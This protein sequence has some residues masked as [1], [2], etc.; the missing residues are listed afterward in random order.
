MG[1]VRRWRS[2][3]GL[4][5]IPFLFSITITSVM[6]NIAWLTWVSPAP[7]IRTVASETSSRRLH[8]SLVTVHSCDVSF[9]AF[10][11]CCRKYSLIGLFKA[12]IRK[13]SVILN[14]LIHLLVGLCFARGKVVGGGSGGDQRGRGRACQFFI[15]Y[16]FYFSLWD[17]N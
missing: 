1:V 17:Q 15:F 16:T 14:W 3:P 13:Q 9:R 11:G 10:W 2:A 5:G 8:I 6:M 12:R 4:D 7:C